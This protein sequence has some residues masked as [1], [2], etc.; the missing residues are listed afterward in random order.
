MNFEEIL[1]LLKVGKKI[2][3][4]DS[5]WI[6][7]VGYIFL[8]RDIYGAPKIRLKY[9]EGRPETYIICSSDLNAD[10]W[11]VVTET[12]KVKLRNLTS[13]QYKNWCKNNCGKYDCEKCIFF[14]INC[15][16]EDS[17]CWIKNKDI[18]RDKFLDQEVEIEE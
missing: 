1:P 7:S 6:N 4:K 8:G 16:Y 14:K 17:H 13:E 9:I 10:D 3:R 18:Y 5:S 15:F 2:R 12:K 11:E